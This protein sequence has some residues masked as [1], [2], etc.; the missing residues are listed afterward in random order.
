M[1]EFKAPEGATKRGV[2]TVACGARLAIGEA[3]AG[4][5]GEL[6]VR[7]EALPVVGRLVIAP[8]AGVIGAVLPQGEDY[9]NAAEDAAQVAAALGLAGIAARLRCCRWLPLDKTEAVDLGLEAVAHAAPLGAG[10]MIGLLGAMQQ[11]RAAAVIRAAALWRAGLARE[12]DD[13]VPGAADEGARA[14]RK[15]LADA[16][17]ADGK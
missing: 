5:G 6:C 11:R 2:Y 3:W 13:E 12:D 9:Q 17:M 14:A 15:V 4:E 10:L 1:D 16:V 7:L 8:D